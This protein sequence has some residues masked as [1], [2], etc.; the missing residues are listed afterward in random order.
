MY[1]FTLG[2]RVTFAR[3]KQAQT[4]QD[5]LQWEMQQIE[6]SLGKD[7]DSAGGLCFGTRVS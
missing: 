2:Q 5:A 6:K 4:L 1:Q 7:G 3:L